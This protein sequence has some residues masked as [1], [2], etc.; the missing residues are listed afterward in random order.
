MQPLKKNEFFTEAD[1]IQFNQLRGAYYFDPLSFVLAAFDWGSAALPSPGP[2]V[3][4]T[5]LLAKIRDEL[6]LGHTT[7]LRF[8]VAS[9][10][11][12]GKTALVAWLVLWQ[13]STRY[14]L[15]GVV[16]ANTLNQLKGKT[17]AEL[18]LWHN[19][20]LHKHW[21]KWTQTNFYCVYDQANWSI[22]S[23]PWSKE[24]PESFAGQH[25]EHSIIIYDEASA[26][27]DIIWENSDG[28]MTDPS[29]FW[30]AF[31]NPTRN[32]GRFKDC[33][34]K[35][36]HRWHIYRVDSRKSAITN[37]EEIA[38]W[39]ADY[40]EDSDFF[41]VRVK[42]E[43]PSAS[44]AQLIPLDTAEAARQR[45]ILMRNVAE[46]PRVMGV[47][48]ARFG[49]DDTVIVIVQGQKMLS[50]DRYHDLTGPE[51]ARIVSGKI[52]Y[53][54]IDAVAVDESNVGSGAYD[55]LREMGYTNVF[56]YHFNGQPYNKSK[57]VNLRAEMWHKMSEW[58]K[59]ADIIDDDKLIDDLVTPEYFYRKDS[60]LIQIESKADIKKKLLRSPDAGD[61]LALIFALPDR[62]VSRQD[63]MTQFKQ[64]PLYEDNNIRLY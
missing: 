4:Q 5:E 44:T 16:T 30:F 17:W 32:T 62:L 52:D 10:H 42:G 29:I 12:V 58:I 57:F 20:L 34:Y 1:A 18:S 3:W 24:K 43:F 36:K 48:C 25:C 2:D 64:R 54:H 28:A 45:D 6:A 35:F 63:K 46:Y 14:P 23:V 33:F 60:Q 31:G 39:A 22:A 47:D 27:D 15:K 40:G 11:G 50:L 38:R 55:T 7:A 53:Q 41:K 37:K 21:F 61:A 51:L 56:G 13:M 9:G 8:A 19:R 49:D 26:I 59:T